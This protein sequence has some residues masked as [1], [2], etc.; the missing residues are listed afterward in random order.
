MDWSKF[1][2]KYFKSNESDIDEPSQKKLKSED[3]KVEFADIGCGYGGLLGKNHT[4]LFCSYKIFGIS[5][6]ISHIFSFFCSFMCICM[7]LHSFMC[8]Y[9]MKLQ[10]LPQIRH[11]TRFKQRKLGT[12]LFHSKTSDLKQRRLFF[13]PGI[14]KKR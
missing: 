5:G 2:P 1:Y 10:S 8:I 7:K 12:Q 9:C 3:Y 13:L 4:M 6:V 14:P 11:H